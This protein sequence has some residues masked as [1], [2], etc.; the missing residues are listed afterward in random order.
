LQ[1]IATLRARG[2]SPDDVR[3]AMQHQAVPTT[4]ANERKAARAALDMRIKTEVGRILG[5][6]SM[7]PQGKDL[8]KK[9][10]NKTNFVIVKATIDKLVNAA[11]QRG[12]GE[13]H[14]FNKT[15][16]ESINERFA[17]LVAAAEREVFSG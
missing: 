17:E 9:H 2:Y 15:E 8:D 4:K 14:E 5:E 10:L 1:A 11:V 3:Q 6:R 13:R 12:A 16:L 7:N